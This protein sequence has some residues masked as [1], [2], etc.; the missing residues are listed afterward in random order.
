MKG[1]DIQQVQLQGSPYDLPN[2]G[3][4]EV[5]D[6]NKWRDVCH[7]GSGKD[8]DWGIE[9]AMVTCR[10]LGYPGTAMTRKGGFGDG[11]LSKSIDSI[12]CEGGI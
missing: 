4:I 2:A 1:V 11:S 9:E 12:N 3:R 8:D 5:Y 6:T 7:D 10:Q